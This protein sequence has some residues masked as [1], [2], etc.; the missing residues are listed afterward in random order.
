MITLFKAPSVQF[1]R[2]ARLLFLTMAV[3]MAAGISQAALAQP[4]DMG[5]GMGGHGGMAM[6]A[7]HHIEHMLDAVN[8]TADQR[9]QIKQIMQAAH[10]DL[11]TQ[12]TAGQSLHQQMQS[13]LAQTTIDARAVETL[14]QQVMAQHDVASKRMSQAMIDAANVLTPA[15]RQTLAGMVAKRQAMMQRHAAERAGLGGAVK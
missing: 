1:T 10:G 14:R 13:L 8:A 3:A 7:G 11:Q 5:M 6:R 2:P 12:R 15:Q 9:A 4:A